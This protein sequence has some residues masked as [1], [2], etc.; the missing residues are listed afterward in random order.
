M[1]LHHLPIHETLL[2]P[3][4]GLP[5]RA[6]GF[7][8]NGRAIW[9]I[10]GGDGTDDDANQDDKKSDDGADDKK[11]DDD[12]K[13]DDTSSWEETFAGMTPAEIKAKLD[14]SRK[15]EERSKANKAKA[16]QYDALAKQIS[17][18]DD[19][20]PPDPEALKGDLTAAQRE[21]RETKI[22]NRVLRVADKHGA[23]GSR[24]VDSRTFMSEISKLDP[25]ADDFGTKVDAAI[26][27]AVEDDPTFGIGKTGPRPVKQQGHPSDGKRLG[28]VAAVMAERAAAREAKK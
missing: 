24:L 12:K 7:R 25:T 6:I 17:G 3:R 13:S 23:V 8:K 26:K 2:H 22:E 4:T 14:N 9:P 18:K 5:L 27:K 28:S 16:D 21:A 1:T 15:W 10:M 19:D 20:A 11:T